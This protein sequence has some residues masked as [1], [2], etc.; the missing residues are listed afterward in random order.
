MDCFCAKYSLLIVCGDAWLA[1]E[2]LR[3]GGDSLRAE[4][5]QQHSGGRHT[6]ASSHNPGSPLG[7]TTFL[8][9]RPGESI[10]GSE[11]SGYENADVVD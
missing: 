4:H 11:P 8:P 2:D 3:P 5:S 9:G 10:K 7:G 6:G 1:L